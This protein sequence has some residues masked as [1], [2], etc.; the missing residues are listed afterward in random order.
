MKEEDFLSTER[1][2]Q[3]HKD[4]MLGFEELNLTKLKGKNLMSRLLSWVY[5]TRRRLKGTK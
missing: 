1:F 2:L 3:V 5:F 4:E